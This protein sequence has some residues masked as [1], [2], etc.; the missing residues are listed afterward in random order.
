LLDA[1]GPRLQRRF[2]A[3]FEEKHFGGHPVVILATADDSLRKVAHA[4][5]RR[6][7]GQLTYV[8][9]D[10]FD[11]PH[12]VVLRGGMVLPPVE[13]RCVVGASF[14]IEDSNP[15]PSAESDAGNL[16]RLEKM[17]SVNPGPGAF[18]NRV[19][20]RAVAPDRL[21]LAGK[22]D[23]GVYG[24]LALG[25]RGLIWSALAAELVAS[26]LE[27]E[28]LP[29]EGMLADALDPGRFERRAKLR[30]EGSPGSRP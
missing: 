8:P 30:R 18:E 12:A 21:P 26:R 24:V 1:C 22:I 4:R 23:E 16:A 25:S 7:R 17:L 27:G 28:P 15:A 29:V 3:P 6:V 5:L 11:P 19:A 9:A 13:G 14:D 20:F 10:R 2:S